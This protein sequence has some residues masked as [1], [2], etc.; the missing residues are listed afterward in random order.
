MRRA[1]RLNKIVHFIRRRRRAVTAD[2]IAQE[3]GVCARTIYRD[4][5]NL[6]DSG[7]PITGE[8]GV[9]YVIDKHYHLPP[10]TF[11]QDELEALSLGIGMVR[12]F[13]DEAFSQKAQCAFEKIQ[14]VLPKKLLR[15][16]EQIN[17]YA[18]PS[19]NRRDWSQH[20]SQMRESIRHRRKM[21]FD[22]RDVKEQVSARTIR[23]LALI[24]A[25]P[26]WILAA[27][28][29]TRQDFRHF[30]L[31]RMNNIV[32]DDTRFDDERD[33]NLAA[34]LRYEA[35]CRPREDD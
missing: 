30:R 3:F 9:G 33:K 17:T 24:F 16:L 20:F 32:F 4:I 10:V 2:R 12:Q 31:D 23:P 25:S 5:Q 15:E 29:E 26:V 21:H 22:Y 14:A 8:A 13:S 34:Y 35:A 28:C 11:D 18:T 1:D 19:K 6:M 27:W 7:V